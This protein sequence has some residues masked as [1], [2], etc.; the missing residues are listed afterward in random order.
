MYNGYFDRNQTVN[1]TEYCFDSGTAAATFG[2]SAECSSSYGWEEARGSN[3][4]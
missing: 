2:A 1:G 3:S 4:T